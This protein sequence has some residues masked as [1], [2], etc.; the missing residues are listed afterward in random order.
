MKRKFIIPIS[1]YIIVWT[2]SV[3]TFWRISPEESAMMYSI[4]VFFIALPIT[5]FITSVSIGLI[6]SKL[7]YLIPVIYGILYMLAE[8]LT[9]SL[10]NMKMFNKVNTLELNMILIGFVISS[11]GLMIGI[12]VNKIKKSN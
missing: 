9:F 12:L 6:Q 11:V 4:M 8:Y 5:T 3:F 7:K 1:I 2:L 10:A